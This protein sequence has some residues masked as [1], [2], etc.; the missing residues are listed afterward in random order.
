MLE[1]A[2]DQL[3]SQASKNMMAQA[4]QNLSRVLELLK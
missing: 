3:L 4:N 2:K 1:Y